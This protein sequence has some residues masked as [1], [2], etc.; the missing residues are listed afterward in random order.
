MAPEGVLPFPLY[1]AIAHREQ[2]MT[3]HG[4]YINKV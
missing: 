1:P 3:E 4:V 2:G